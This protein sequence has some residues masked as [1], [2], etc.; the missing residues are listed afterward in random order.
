MRSNG[1][2]KKN[3]HENVQIYKHVLN[4][5]TRRFWRTLPHVGIELF[6]VSLSLV[7]WIFILHLSFRTRSTFPATELDFRLKLTMQ[8]KNNPPQEREG[9]RVKDRDGSEGGSE[10]RKE[11]C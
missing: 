2:F 7:F 9:A 6:D 8:P 5:F 10:E 11:G 4:L 3:I 1:H